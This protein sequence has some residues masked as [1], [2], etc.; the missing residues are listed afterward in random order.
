MTKLTDD[1][2]ALAELAGITEQQAVQYM[3]LSLIPTAERPNYNKL[4]LDGG[5]PKILSAWIEAYVEK[6]D[7]DKQAFLDSISDSNMDRHGVLLDWLLDDISD[8]FH[9][10]AR[11]EDDF[12][13]LRGRTAL[14]FAFAVGQLLN[15]VEKKLSGKQWVH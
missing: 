13:K 6:D 5:I 2:R 12:E 8:R 10:D 1:Q 11:S 4:L 14:R 15:D 3:R 9:I 7:A